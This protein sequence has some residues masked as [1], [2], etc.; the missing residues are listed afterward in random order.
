[1]KM[2]VSAVKA[3]NGNKEN[4]KWDK[5]CTDEALFERHSRA[6]HKKRNEIWT[7]FSHF[8]GNRKS[9]D[10]FNVHITISKMQTLLYIL[11]I[12]LIINALLLFFSVN[13]NETKT[14]KRQQEPPLINKWVEEEKTELAIKKGRW[15]RMISKNKNWK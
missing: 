13:R 1:M 7:N 6:K 8:L 5:I 3:H 14:P 4:R 15:L 10:E 11:S 9:Q 12:L 2:K